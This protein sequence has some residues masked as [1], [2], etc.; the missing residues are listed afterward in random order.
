MQI[1]R[2]ENRI[3]QLKLILKDGTEVDIVEAGYTQHYVVT[4]A[5]EAAFKGIWEKMTEDNLS[6]IQITEDGSTVHTITGS[7]LSG[8]QTVNNPDGTVTGHFYLTGG[9]YVQ[10]TDD[11]SEAGKILLGEEG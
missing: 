2:K 5:D 10:A 1:F 7:S 3:M 9:E 4:C 11:Y 8:T 6:E